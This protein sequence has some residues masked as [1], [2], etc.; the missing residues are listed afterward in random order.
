MLMRN[1]AATATMLIAALGV[2]AGTAAADPAAADA[3]INFT[4]ESTDTQAIVS[5]DAGSIVVEDGALKI[6]AANGNVVAGTPLKFRLDEF[7]FP[8][9]ADI[10]GR[11]ATLTPQLDMSKAVYKPVALP[12]EDKAP[13]KS[14]YDREQAAWSRMTGT[15]SLGASIA[16]LVG[17][18]GGAAVGCVLGGIVGGAVVGGTIVGLFG[19]FL[20]GIAAGCLGGAAAM[21]ALGTVAGQIF[22]T[23]PVAIGAAIQYFTTINQPFNPAK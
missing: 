9:A 4:A 10:A 8:I 1:L 16:T 13:W 15:I 20:G 11:T 22:I 3:P 21:G 2:A 23:A 19:P 18:L 12:F 6:K 14:E 17:G 5:L 7:E